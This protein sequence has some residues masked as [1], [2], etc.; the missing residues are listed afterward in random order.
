M[1]RA[2][3]AMPWEQKLEA[4]GRSPS[5]GN[6]VGGV[7]FVVIREALRSPITRPTATRR[8][9]SSPSPMSTFMQQRVSS[10]CFEGAVCS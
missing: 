8:Q 4:S 2:I 5:F 1:A 9:E 3:N 6:K 7:N 10:G